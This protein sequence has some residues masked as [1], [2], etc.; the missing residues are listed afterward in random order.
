MATLQ[1]IGGKLTFNTADLQKAT[2]KGIKSLKDLVVAE[3]QLSQSFQ[4]DFDGM[5][6]K[7]EV[8]G[9]ELKK[10]AGDL[11][12]LQNEAADAKR[13]LKEAAGEMTLFGVSVA[14]ASALLTKYRKIHIATTIAIGGSTKALKLFR[15]TLIGTGVGALVVGLGALIV[16]L[17]QTQKGIDIVNVAMGNIVGPLRVATEAFGLLGL[18]IVGGISPIRVFKEAFGGRGGVIQ[19][20]KDA[21]KVTKEL[22]LEQIVLRD[23]QRAL[24][25]SFAESRARIADLKII[26]DD[27]TKTYKQ[28][29][30]A[31]REA[32]DLELDILAQR[33]ELQEKQIGQLEQK[34]VADENN[35]ERL[36]VIN[37]AKI[38]LEQTKEES[39]GKQAEILATVNGLIAG[40]K[41]EVDAL[42]DSYATMAADIAAQVLA[43]D[44]EDL[45]PAARLLKEKEISL[46]ALRAYKIDLL[47]LADEI[48]KDVSKVTLAGLVRVE[49]EIVQKFKDGKKALQD[50]YTD[51]LSDVTALEFI[52]LDPLGKLEKQRR[53]SIETLT[54]L[55]EILEQKADDAGKKLSDKTRDLLVQLRKDIDK[56]FTDGVAGLGDAYADML[57][58]LSAQVDVIKFENLDPL[59]KLQEQKEASLATVDAL[60]IELKKKAEESGKVLTK[61][62]TDQLQFLRDA[63]VKNFDEAVEGLGE[64]L[65]NLQKALIAGNIIFESITTAFAS[66]IDLQISKIDE[67]IEAQDNKLSKLEEE[68]EKEKEFEEL[69]LATRKENL[70]AEIDNEIAIKEKAIKRRSELE[71][72]AQKIQ[73][74]QDSVTQGTA[75]VTSAAN[76]YKVFTKIGGPFGIAL[77]VAAIG[78]M[79]ASFAKVKI[80]ALKATKLYTGTEEGPVGTYM[81]QIPGHKSDRTGAGYGVM[82]METGRDT[83]VRL[84]ADEDIMKGDV[85]R[86]HGRFLRELN[87]NANKYRHRNLYAEL[88]DGIDLM[89]GRV[90]NFDDVDIPD[91]DY[92]VKKANKAT[93]RTQG[94]I[95]YGG[96]N[97]EEMGTILQ[98]ELKNHLQNIQSYDKQKKII[99]Y[100]S[101]VPSHA[102]VSSN[103]GK[104]RDTVSL[105]K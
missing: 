8:F 99:T 49:E 19:A 72:K 91:K 53:E 27:T 4:K 82:D 87:K 10:G 71:A 89:G 57:A 62:T 35:I 3:T 24:N 20:M 81:S 11:N 45:D 5:T 70:Q 100:L 69:G 94:I 25:L 93:R 103:G 80:D 102:V 74:L 55:T 33:I 97:K 13:T 46:E 85:S 42:R 67:L 54:T 6:D 34:I 7:V 75:L 76:L 30:A 59:A 96:L 38:V 68:L 40:Q 73:L 47:A 37:A 61:E 58:G 36:D 31:A 56:V 44:L 9:K 64:G 41:G 23:A 29:I 52:D 21:A 17:T 32:G 39:F 2:G 63:I 26:S 51:A 78:A 15:L 48:D 83:G 79:F 84:G 104:S 28:R 101:D 92:A 66:G 18:A 88:I 50:A 12:K 60:E 77:A 65:T 105:P 98:S 90:L 43:I 22:R 95:L 14:S 86:R 1:E 16:F